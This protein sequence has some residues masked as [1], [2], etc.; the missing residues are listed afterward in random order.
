VSPRSALEG[1]GKE[2][3]RGARFSAEEREKGKG[4]SRSGPCDNISM[5]EKGG[6]PPWLECIQ[7]YTLVRGGGERE[8]KRT[9]DTLQD[10][11]GYS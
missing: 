10:E 3:N 2:K 8:K 9:P 4:N 5:G 11:K 6:L 1:G 7:A